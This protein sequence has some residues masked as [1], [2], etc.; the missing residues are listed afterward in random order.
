MSGGT[1]IEKLKKRYGRP[2][3]PP[4]H[5]SPIVR[6]GPISSKRSLQVSLQDPFWGK[7][8]NFS[9]YI[10]NFCPNF[11]SQA[12][13]FE[14]FSSQDFSFRGAGKNQFTSP[15]LQDS[16]PHSPTWKKSSALPWRKWCSVLKLKTLI[17]TQTFLH[18]SKWGSVYWLFEST[19]CSKCQVCQLWKFPN[20][21]PQKL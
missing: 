2:W 18:T 3:R 10:L 12:P 1:D 13:K 11:S 5:A 16:K 7:N 20:F 19:L 14:N 6:K 4:F 8:G 17:S 21:T 15:T 9:L